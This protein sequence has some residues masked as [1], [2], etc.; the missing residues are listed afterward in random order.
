M[1]VRA[2]ER[3]VHLAVLASLLGAPTSAKYVKGVVNTK[4]VRELLLS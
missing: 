2:G 4:E 1:E 3:L